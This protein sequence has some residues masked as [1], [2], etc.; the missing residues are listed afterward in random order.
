[1]ATDLATKKDE[2]KEKINEIKEN[3]SPIDLK[4][5]TESLRL[6]EIRLKAPSKD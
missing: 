6:N 1:M 4:N 3:N 5:I 2:I